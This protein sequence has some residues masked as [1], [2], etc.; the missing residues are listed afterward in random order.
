ML[1]AYK[2]SATDPKAKEPVITFMWEGTNY[3][4]KMR[5]DV[6][7][8]AQHSL[9]KYFNFSDKS[10]P[11]LVIPSCAHTG[12]GLKGLKKTR[13][14]QAKK[15]IVKD[16]NK[17][18]VPLDNSL[19][20]RIRASEIT[21]ENESK[22]FTNDDQSSPQ[23]NKT[24][25]S[26]SKSESKMS[27]LN[28]E[29]ANPNKS[30][31]G[32]VEMASNKRESLFDLRKKKGQSSTD[33]LN[34]NKPNVSSKQS[35]DQIMQPEPSNPEP[36][37]EVVEPN[38]EIEEDFEYSLYPLNISESDLQTYISKYTV[39]LDD[40]LGKS[41]VKSD[42]ILAKMHNGNNAQAYGLRN[43]GSTRDIDGLFVYSL[44]SHF[45]RLNIYHLSTINKKGLEHAI[46]VAI[47]HI[48][49]NEDTKEI[50]MGLYHFDGE[51]DGKTIKVVDTEL[52]DALKKNKLRWKNI[53][54]EGN[55][56]ILVMGG[57]RNDGR[58]AKNQLDQVLMVK[59]GLV[60]STTETNPGHSEQTNDTSDLNLLPGL[61]FNSLLSEKLPENGEDDPEQYKKIHEIVTDVQ[62]S[63]LDAFPLTVTKKES[64]ASTAAEDV[65]NEG[66]QLDASK[67]PT[68][69]AKSYH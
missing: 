41:F 43:K 27:N 34:E 47:K 5:S 20:Q 18:E 6:N 39:K 48:W 19:M 22:G 9:A 32:D 66:I 7:Y 3:L 42:E 51:K 25:D 58:E 4:V 40:N 62:T 50:R 14:K 28:N 46:A 11:F 15:R 2:Q 68:S 17:Y 29:N 59:S 67:L 52:K 37:K 31:N 23:T 54:N 55:E 35:S 8:L 21:I 57:I 56:R 38:E 65:A 44:D 33:N 24:V 63:K 12:V 60:L 1:Y 13:K 30:L 45:D 16:G 53:L 26:P 69:G 36:I 49:D 61:Y 10:D 64:D